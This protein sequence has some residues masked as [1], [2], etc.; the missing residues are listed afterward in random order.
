MDNYLT[1]L[2]ITGTI[3]ASGGAVAQSAATIAGPQPI[4]TGSATM[5]VLG[6]YTDIFER[7][8]RVEIHVPGTG[9][10][11]SAQWRWSDAGGVVPIVWNASNI[12]TSP[13]SWSPLNFGLQ[14]RFD[15]GGPFAPHFVVG[16]TQLFQ[17]VHKYGFAKALDG[18]RDTE[19]R[20]GISPRAARSSGGCNFLQS[21]NRRPLPCWM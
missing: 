16:D 8:Y 10:F 20:S 15:S 3:F 14:V 1:S 13:G 7:L 11:G 2:P 18:T 21:C 5:T 9:A 4:K 19:W 6:T 12:T 17:A